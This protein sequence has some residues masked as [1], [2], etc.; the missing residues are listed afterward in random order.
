VVQALDAVKSEMDTMLTLNEMLRQEIQHSQSIIQSMAIKISQY[1][2]TATNMAELSKAGWDL[3]DEK[4][5]P[6]LQSELAITESS[7]STP[8]LSV[9][10]KRTGRKPS[11]SAKGIKQAAGKRSQKPRPLLL[12]TET[13]ALTYT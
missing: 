4:P 6:L 5:S 13:D 2:N 9:V 8:Q 11:G 12:N 1:E 7:V 10:K 3:H